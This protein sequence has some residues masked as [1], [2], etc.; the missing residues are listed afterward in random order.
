MKKLLCKDNLFTA[1]VS[2]FITCCVMLYFWIGFLLFLTGCSYQDAGI[3]GA[4]GTA[5]IQE[6][7][8]GKV[9]RLHIIADS[10]ADM[11][12]EIKLEIKDAVV[13]Y[14]RPCLEGVT[15]KEEAIGV[16]SERLDKLEGIAS[17]ILADGGFQYTATATLGRS[18]FPIKA[19]GDLTLPAGEY[20]AL[21]ISLGSASGKNWWCLVFPQLCFVDITY[22]TVPEESRE[23]LKSILSEEEYELVF[24]PSGTN[25]NIRIRWKIADL[26][27]KWF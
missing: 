5:P 27:K 25:G 7:V 3:P 6:S 19:Y 21:K 12:Q 4:A 9:L 24:A 22:G 20:D 26:F 14:L 1:L 13:T 23:S 18:Y 10:N 2:L 8:A 15:T 11:D 16:I 17:Q